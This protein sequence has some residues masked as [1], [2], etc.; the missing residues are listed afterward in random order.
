MKEE[1]TIGE[2][3]ARLCDIA[4]EAFALGERFS[5]EKLVR[6]TLRSLPKRFAY[7]VTA[8]EEAKDIQKMKLGELIGSLKTFEM[9]LEEERGEKKEKGVALQVE[10]NEYVY[11]KMMMI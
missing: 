4:N 11:I 8:I 6:K 10:E 9:N 1:E 3:N 7:K 5:E 2:F